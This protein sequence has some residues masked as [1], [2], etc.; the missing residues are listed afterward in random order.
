MP[1]NF[2]VRSLITTLME[3]L[4]YLSILATK[5]QGHLLLKREDNGT[6]PE[7]VE[8]KEQK[9]INKNVILSGFLWHLF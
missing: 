2:R 7:H 5:L 3:R 1:N 6:Q 4:N 8:K 9:S